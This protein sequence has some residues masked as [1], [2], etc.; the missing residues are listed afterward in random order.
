M[1]HICSKAAEHGSNVTGT[2]DTCP[3]PANITS[4]RFCERLILEQWAHFLTGVQF[5]LSATN[6]CSGLICNAAPRL[7]AQQMQ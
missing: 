5:S 2:R 6:F 7:C 3:N 4:C 1:L